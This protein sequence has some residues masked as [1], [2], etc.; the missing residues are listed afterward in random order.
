MA[1]KKASKK[2]A[3][4]VSQKK[5]IEVKPTINLWKLSN[6]LETLANKIDNVKSALDLIAQNVMNDPESGAIWMVVDALQVHIDTLEQHSGD[7]M[8]AHRESM[9]SKQQKENEHLW[10]LMEDLR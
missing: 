10:K 4:K 2:L 7:V 8:K 6:D 9:P 5:V 1:A 3:T